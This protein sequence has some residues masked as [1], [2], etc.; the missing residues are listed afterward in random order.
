MMPLAEQRTIA[1]G[2]PPVDSSTVASAGRRSRG[3]F[4]S[5]LRAGLEVRSDERG[6]ETVTL[7]EVGASFP[8]EDE[9]AR[10]VG[11]RRQAEV[12]PVVEFPRQNAS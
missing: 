2:S 8:G 10:P 5:S 11:L 12:E 1:C 3:V 4:S 7:G 6:D 9:Y